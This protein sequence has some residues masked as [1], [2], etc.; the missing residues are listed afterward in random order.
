MDGQLEHTSRKIN[1]LTLH[2]VEAGP[3]HGP[4]VLLLHGFPEFWYGWRHQIS[5]LADAGFRTLVPD[6]RGY[7]ES[8]KP[9]PVSAYALD[10]L[11]DD[12][13]GLIQST[14]RPRASLVGHDWGGVVAWWV[15][16]KYPEVV[17]RFVAINAPHPV[18]FRRLLRTS[19]VQ[20]LRSYYML[21]FQTPW[22]P[23]I[24]LRLSNWRS[25][26]DILRSAS[27]PGTFTDADFA[28]YRDA[29]S[30]PG[31]ITAMINWYRAAVR[32][33]SVWSESGTI[34]AMVNSSLGRLGIRPVP[35]SDVRVHV[36][37]LVIWGTDDQFLDSRLAQASVAFCDD[38]AL[39][40][41]NR[42]THWVHHEEPERVNC[43]LVD[44]LKQ[45]AGLLSRQSDERLHQQ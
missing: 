6:Q 45:S 10:K 20:R 34:N 24:G 26:T 37:T 44:F 25:L 9:R 18:A 31:A 12:A 29:W 19:L 2:V 27:R 16:M 7:G 30:Q 14:G 22:L 39:R 3:A 41:I 11:A 40:V 5:A 42:A 23:E 8:D 1:G 15:A 4:A 43:L 17:D 35:P 21:G 33:R 36:P 38:G 28:R 32:N 13:V